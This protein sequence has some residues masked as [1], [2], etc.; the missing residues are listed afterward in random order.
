MAY[1]FI[2]EKIYHYINIRPKNIILAGDSSG[3]NLALSIEALLLQ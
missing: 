2:I 3:G 1:K